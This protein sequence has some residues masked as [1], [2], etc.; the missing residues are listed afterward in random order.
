MH[1]IQLIHY[2]K[3]IIA[4]VQYLILSAKVLTYFSLRCESVAVI[5]DEM[6]G[7]VA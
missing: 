4:F 3:I 2:G 1:L 7:H 6:E 5:Q